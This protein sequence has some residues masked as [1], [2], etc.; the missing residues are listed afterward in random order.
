MRQENK[1]TASET[2]SYSLTQ[3]DIGRNSAW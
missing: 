2:N 1:E 3:K